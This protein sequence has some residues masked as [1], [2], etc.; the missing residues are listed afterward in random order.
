M[1][2]RYILDEG[3]QQLFKGNRY[4]FDDSSPLLRISELG[5]TKV[6]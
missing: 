3:C 2:E 1:R 4:R 6:C 5:I